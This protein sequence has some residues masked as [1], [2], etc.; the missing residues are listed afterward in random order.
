MGGYVGIPT[1]Y[2]PVEYIES[3][4]TQWINTNFK[5]TNNTKIE[6]KISNFP[7]N[8]SWGC[9]V[10]ARTSAG[11]SDEYAFFRTDGGLYRSDFAGNRVTFPSDTDLTNET[12][13]VK[14]GVN[15][16][17]NGTTITNTSATFTGAYPLWIFAC[18][19]G[20]TKANETSFRL[21]YLK[22]WDSGTL[23][24]DFVPTLNN[25]VVCL[26]DLVEGKFYYNAGTGTFT[27]GA[28][29]EPVSIDKARKMIAGDVGVSTSYTPVEYIESSGTQWINTGAT[30]DSTFKIDFDATIV[31]GNANVWMPVWGTRTSTT[32]DYC[33][34][35]VNTD[36]HYLS[37]N[38]AGFDPRYG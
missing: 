26:L 36:T 11:A 33:A 24:R 18:N 8:A 13:V 2:T 16:T 21:Y 15:T 1:S 22:I 27:A 28:A 5:A 9:V 35:Y 10:G 14:D 38:Y 20:G 32:A 4:G 25:N 34:L 23:V 37:P 6:F 7:P 30:T 12:I 31:S 19:N 3:S 29:G 17:I